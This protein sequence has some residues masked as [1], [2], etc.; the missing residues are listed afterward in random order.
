MLGFRG[1]KVPV[2][3]TGFGLIHACRWQ[4]GGYGPQ[5]ARDHSKHFALI[6]VY[7]SG[8]F[9]V[10]PWNPARLLAKPSSVY[11]ADAGVWVCRRVPLHAAADLPAELVEASDNL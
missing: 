8:S 6:E 3:V 10:S 1:R 2:K 5:A 9:H 11:H 7:A 4:L